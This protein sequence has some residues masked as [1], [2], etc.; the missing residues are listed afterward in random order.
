MRRAAAL[1]ASLAAGLAT[2]GGI[3]I[4]TELQGCRQIADR[5][6]RLVCFDGLAS[7]HSP[8]RYAGRHG[9]TTDAFTID[10][11][12][13]LRYQSDGAIFVMYLRDADGR[14]VQNLVLHGGGEDRYRIDASGTYS[15][16]INGSETWRIW[17]EAP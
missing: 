6:E 4:P 16:Q 17:V 8:P 3:D 5:N 10:A 11:P 12:Q 13:Q 9:A 15:L 2:A 1:A 14:V 7:R